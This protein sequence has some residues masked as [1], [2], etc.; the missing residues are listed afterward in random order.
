MITNGGSTIAWGYSTE[1]NGSFTT[2]LS[3]SRISLED[4]KK[5]FEGK[6]EEN[7]QST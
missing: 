1:A 7:G 6:C 2:V 5:N 4:M 3:E